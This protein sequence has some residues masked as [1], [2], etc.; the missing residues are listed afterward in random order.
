M[1]T[2]DELYDILSA[3]PHNPHYLD[4]YIKFILSCV[5][6]R[7][8][9][10]Y[11][12]AHHICP[13]ANALFPQY[14]AFGKNK[15]NKAVLTGRQHLVA[16]WM[17]SKAFTGKAGDDMKVAFW[18]MCNGSVTPYTAVTK[19][20]VSSR[21]YESA[22]HAMSDSIKGDKN[23]MHRKRGSLHHFFGTS[24][25][26]NGK[27]HSDETKHQMSANAT[28][29]LNNFHGKTHSDELKARMALRKWITNGVKNSLI[30]TDTT[31]VPDGWWYGKTV[32]YVTC[33]N[34]NGQYD[35]P[36]FKRHHASRCLA[37]P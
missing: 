5:S 22:K 21:M 13:R 25:P 31:E 11:T 16:H 6:K 17:L 18:L 24:G 19:Y 8:V 2:Y 37:Q 34:C 36:N 23:P 12:E 10:V 20:T 7:H 29:E 32:K 28:G 9:A 15:W 30:Y 14:S 33:P 1:K 26:M 35:A 27:T 4:R 3:K